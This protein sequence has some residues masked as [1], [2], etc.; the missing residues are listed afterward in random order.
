L[1]AELFLMCRASDPVTVVAAWHGSPQEHID[2]VNGPQRVEVKSSGNRQRAHYFSLL[3][4]QPPVST[5]LIVASMF[6]E[7]AGGGLS[8]R[9]LC[10]EIRLK[11]I[12]TP[13]LLV[14]FDAVFYAT[15]GAG[16]PDAMEEAFD[17]ELATESLQFF[18]ALDIPMVAG[19]IPV[20]VSQVRFNSDL[21][22][23]SPYAHVLLGRAGGLFAAI[24]PA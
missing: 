3:Q 21:S 7:R 24:R 12:G 14:H 10:D 1:W 23:V 5:M 2:F 15:L 19:P 22:N 8:M 4:L 20:E 6:V 18:H 11:L 16:W 17:A 13:Q 9:S